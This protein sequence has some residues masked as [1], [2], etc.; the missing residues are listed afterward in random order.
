MFD[1]FKLA[2]NLRAGGEIVNYQGP[3]DKAG[4]LNSLVVA[5]S[6]KVDVPLPHSLRERADPDVGRTVGLWPSG[7]AY[8]LTFSN[9]TFVNFDRSDTFAWGDCAMCTLPN[10][11]NGLEM[12]YMDGIT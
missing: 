2:D 7:L 9:I 1:G 10:N 8:N 3:R 4:F 5:H 12:N 11:V 6:D